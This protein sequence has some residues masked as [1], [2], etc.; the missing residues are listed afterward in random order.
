MKILS[1]N[2]H[3]AAPILINNIP[4]ILHKMRKITDKT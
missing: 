3:Q 4:V 1:G 2:K